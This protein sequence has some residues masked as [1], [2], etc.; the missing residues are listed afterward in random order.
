[1]ARQAAVDEASEGGTVQYREAKPIQRY[2]FMHI[3][4]TA[5][6]T[7]HKRLIHHHGD[8][9]YPLPP[10]RGEI[11]AAIDVDWVQNRFRTNAEQIRIVVGHFPLCLDELLRVPLT[12][13]TLMRHPV[14]RTLSFLRRRQRDP[15]YRSASLEEIYA[16]PY[17]LH[18]LIHNYMVKVL[19]LTVDEA[20]RGVRTM[21]PHDD[22]RLERAK[23]NLQHRIETF[24][25]QEDFEGFCK[26]LAVRFG[27]DLAGPTVVNRTEP[28][29]VTDE[30]HERIAHDNAYDVDLYSFAK[31]LLDARRHTS[32]PIA[33]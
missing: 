2:F 29:D 16:D 20:R 1:M 3:P 22:S 10:D 11:D 13:F 30:F 32:T 25:L 4:K 28:V 6:T 17:L 27:W 19:T 18:G 31:G 33:R 8:A 12:T 23:H 21:V 15:Q 5:G 9:L 26:H 24:G 14:E 7:L